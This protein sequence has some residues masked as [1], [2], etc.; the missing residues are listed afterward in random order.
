MKETMT[1]HKALC[2]LKILNSRIEDT[3]NET[4]FLAV[5]KHS[6]QKINGKTIG[7][8]IN[9]SRDKYKSIRTL[10]N[11]RN[12]IKRAVVKSNAVTTVEIDGVTY[13]VA[14]AIDMK[15]SGINNLGML[16]ARLEQQWRQMSSLVERENGDKLENR[17]DEYVKSLYGT[18][19]MKNMSDE[20]RKTRETFVESQKSDLIDPLD[21]QEVLDSLR[22]E[23]DG[24]MSE[25]DSALSV[26]NAL[27]TVEVEYDTL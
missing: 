21:T 1:I 14:E 10:I 19:E 17:A 5:N 25:V 24:F 18:S 26:S 6:N 12:A 23:I 11:R 3:I 16:R 22:A 15:S 8:F 20:I 13:T 7:E 2:E 27:T 4:T 9:Y